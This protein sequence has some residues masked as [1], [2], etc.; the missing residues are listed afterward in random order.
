MFVP[1]AIIGLLSIHG[2]AALGAGDGTF[3]APT[4][5]AVSQPPHWAASGRF[6]PDA[7]PGLAVVHMS[8][9][10]TIFVPAPGGT[11]SLEEKPSLGI[12]NGIWHVAAADFDGDGFDDLV[13]A[14]PGSTVYVVRC[15]G[16]GTFDEAVSLG[17]TGTPRTTA[18]ADYD[19]DGDLDLAIVNH[20]LQS[21]TIYLGNG[22]ASFTHLETMT[23]GIEE[24]NHDLSRIDFNGDGNMDLI[25]AVDFQGLQLLQGTGGAKFT[26]KPISG[27][28]VPSAY[29]VAG[30]KFDKDSF[31]DVV[32]IWND[33]GGLTG[34]AGTSL[35]N[36]TFETATTISSVSCLPGVGDMDGDGNTDLIATP[37]GKGTIEIHQGN[38]DGTFSAP[39]VFGGGPTNTVPHILPVDLDVDGNLDLVISDFPSLLVIGGKG[40]GGLGLA[41]SLTGYGPARALAIA[42]ID[43]NG[44]PDVLTAA[45][46]A[47]VSVFLEPGKKGAADNTPDY[48][49]ETKNPFTSLE[50]VDLDGNGIVDLV[51]TNVGSSAVAVSILGADGKPA[52]EV[53]LPAGQIPGPT[54]VGRIDGDAILD[55][56]VPCTGSQEIVLFRGAGGGDFADA[57]H[58][59]SIAKP[60][61]VI[62][63]DLDADGITDLAVISQTVL[64]IHWG[65]G[66]WTFGEATKLYEKSTENFIDLAMGDVDGDGAQDLALA[67]TRTPAI[68]A[69]AKGAGRSF[70][71]PKTMILPEQTPSISLPDLDG[72]GYAELVV[73]APNSSAALIYK[74]AGGK[75]TG[76]PARYGTGMGATA[77]RLADLN[78]DGAPD[79][80]GFNTSRAAILF[81]KGGTAGAFR[82]GD[83][84]GDGQVVIVDAVRILESLFQGGGP[85]ACEDGADGNDDGVLDI[86]DPISLL[87]H[88]FLGGGALPSPSACAVDPTPDSLVC[89]LACTG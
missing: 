32:A 37:N 39:T 42:D 76:G 59:P 7:S 12:G 82:R 73:M 29:F 55:L 4:S 63:A 53:L 30:A 3:Q 33:N 56:A 38:G 65:E 13:I 72:D 81:G 70:D 25:L 28:L 49:I 20:P 18:I 83:V 34:V 19:N 69:F 15:R 5:I 43:R 88:L 84:D 66:N 80:V 50:A 71:G 74:N 27:E 62:P 52:K 78:G 87:T 24:H 17:Q 47:H 89:T 61:R 41:S 6:T 67:E 51:G 44:F 11:G 48:E 75:W 23:A 40:K 1:F 46:K 22:D 16:D 54:M 31:G 9:L 26:P 79:L 35:G 10:V 2:P 85:L 21:I 57:I 36:G 60:R 45:V 68:I 86:A 14:D 64:A 58:V 8:N 77:H